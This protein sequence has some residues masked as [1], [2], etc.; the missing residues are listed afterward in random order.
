MQPIWW[1][2]HVRFVKPRPRYALESMGNQH[3]PVHG[4]TPPK[5]KPTRS[6]YDNLAPRR[7]LGSTAQW[8]IVAFLLVVAVVVIFIL[9]DGGDFNPNND[10]VVGAAARAV[11]Q[12]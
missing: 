11:I 3:R 4:T 6:K 7:A 12:G 5:G 10:G 1:R 2:S 9:V 8:M